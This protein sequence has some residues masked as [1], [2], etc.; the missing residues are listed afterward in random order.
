MRRRLQFILLPLALLG[1]FPAQ[2]SGAHPLSGRPYAG[3]MGA[4]WLERDIEERPRLAVR[5]PHLR[6]GMTV[7]DS[8]AGSGYYTESPSHAAGPSGRAFAVDIQAGM[9]RLMKGRMRRQKLDN[10]T[11]VLGLAADP[12]LP[13]SSINLALLVDV[14]REISDPQPLLRRRRSALR[15]DGRLILLEFRKEDPA[16]PIR[17][18]HKM[19]VEEAKTEI[20]PEGLRLDSVVEDLPWQHILIFR[21]PQTVERRYSLLRQA[22][23]SDTIESSACL[24]IPLTAQADPVSWIT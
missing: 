24:P 2:D 23:A 20:E 15:P 3:A 14:Y 5:L 12:K 11:P 7:A 17:L 21:K 22:A 19:S 9:I 18:E 1:R 16:K 13:E 4:P 6:L 10:V 8:G